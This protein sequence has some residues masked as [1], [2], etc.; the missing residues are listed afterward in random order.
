MKAGV[1]MKSVE[2]GQV[3]K[4]YK[5]LCEHLGEPVKVGKSKQLQMKDWERYFTY[6]KSGHSL[7]IVSVHENPIEKTERT[8]NNIKNIKS[9][10]ELIQCCGVPTQEAYNLKNSK[11]DVITNSFGYWQSEYYKIFN[12][13]IADSIYDGEKITDICLKND[14]SR[15][16]LYCDYISLARNEFKIMFRK[17]LSYLQKKKLVEYSEGYY[18][19]YALSSQSVGRVIT[20]FLSEITKEIE[21]TIC[22]EMN[23]ENGFSSK[24]SGR[25][26][27]FF[28]Y[29]D[30]SLLKEYN[31][32]CLERLMSNTEAIDILNRELM[33]QIPRYIPDVNSICAERPITSYNCVVSLFS[34]EEKDGDIKYLTTDVSNQIRKKVRKLLYKKSYIDEETN[35]KIHPYRS[36]DAIREIVQIEKL[37]Y[38]YFDTELF[39]DSE[40]LYEDVDGM[41]IDNYEEHWLSVI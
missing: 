17:A 30:E 41:D 25:Q 39:D 28:I 6:K 10:I 34:V 20:P 11:L 33:L 13:I 16:V 15:E 27:L 22:D 23:D 12:K 14:I 31:R 4:N 38:R 18:F 7:I 37:L 21:T 29:K 5:E 2:S 26:I 40:A 19:K 9:M 35:K 36:K 1:Y 24:I 3:F 32:R 8:S